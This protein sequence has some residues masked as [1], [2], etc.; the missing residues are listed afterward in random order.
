MP[1]SVSVFSQRVHC[2]R[3]RLVQCVLQMVDGIGR[4]LRGLRGIVED[5]PDWIS[6]A[7]VL[8]PGPAWGS[9]RQ[10]GSNQAAVTL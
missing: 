5:W 8:S 6:I 4:R 3:V 10:R 1:A 9:E 7:G 2:E